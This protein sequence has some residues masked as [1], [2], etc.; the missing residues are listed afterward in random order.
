[1]KHPNNYFAKFAFTVATS[2]SKP[3]NKQPAKTMMRHFQHTNERVNNLSLHYGRDSTTPRRCY[4]VISFLQGK[5]LTTGQSK[6]LFY[7]TLKQF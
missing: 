3:E 1:M 6:R 4:R 2:L 5:E 7:K